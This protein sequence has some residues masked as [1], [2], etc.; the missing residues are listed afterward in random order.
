MARS[1]LTL[2]SA[3]VTNTKSVK[4][5]ESIG[6]NLGRAEG[7]EQPSICPSIMA[8]TWTDILL[9]HELWMLKIRITVTIRVIYSIFS[10]FPLCLLND[11]RDDVQSEWQKL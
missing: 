2:D 10:V 1:R 4:P 5:T 7:I 9:L 11:P 6:W 8:I 3:N